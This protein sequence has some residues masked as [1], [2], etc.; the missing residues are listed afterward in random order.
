[1]TVETNTMQQQILLATIILGISFL[2]ANRLGAQTFT[3]PSSDSVAITYEV[4]GKGTPALVFVHGWSC[5]RSYWREQIEQFSHR[6]KVVAIDLAGHGESGT[7][8]K[9][10][11]IESF[12]ADVA[13]VVNDL[14]LQRVI[15]IGH[16]MGGDVIAAAARLLPHEQIAGLVMVDT[17][18]KLGPGRT[19]EQVEAFVAKFRTDFKD[20][21]RSFVRSM[22][23]TYADSA[24]VEWV[25]NDMS[26][27]PPTIAISALQSAFSYSREITKAL[28]E[29]KLPV[30]AIN[31]DNSPTDMASMQ[32]YGVKVVII[33]RVGHFIMMED[34]KRFNEALETV[35]EKMMKQ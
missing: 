20:S 30:T 6:Y 25:A 3:T 24:L 18:K 8:R 22:F 31:S 35:I 16:S 28:S 23:S 1:M 14:H 15:L 5:D 27:A 13:A 32:R 34:T 7:E 9:S 11:T 26:S 10:Y 12:G 2:S 17:Y 21:V 4:H 29:V 19:P 33:P